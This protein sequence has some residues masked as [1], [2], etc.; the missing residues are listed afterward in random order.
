MD[1]F[2]IKPKIKIKLTQEDIDDI[3]CAALEGGIN[4]WCYRADVVGGE[5]LGEWA[6][7]QIA[8]GGRL[9]LFD[10]ESDDTWVLTLN[11][12]LNGFRLWIEKGYDRNGACSSNGVDCCLIDAGDADCIVQLALFGDVIFG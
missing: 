5:Y 10:A 4:Y 12:F 9:K 1:E 2:V 6:H 3:M 7:E 8:R 11:K